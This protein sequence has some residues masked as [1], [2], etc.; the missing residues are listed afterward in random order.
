V[1][2]FNRPT[3]VCWQNRYLNQ[4]FGERANFLAGAW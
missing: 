2:R 4:L 1:I 3:G